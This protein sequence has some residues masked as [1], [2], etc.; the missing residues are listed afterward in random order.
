MAALYELSRV[1]PGLSG[2]YIAVAWVALGTLLVAGV[3]YAALMIDGVM[4]RETYKAEIVEAIEV[5]RSELLVQVG[6]RWR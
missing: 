5:E 4:N 6:I 2:W 1:V 3:D